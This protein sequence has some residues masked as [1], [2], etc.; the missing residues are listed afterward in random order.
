MCVCGQ[1]G[2]ESLSGMLL[3]SGRASEQ[4]QRLGVSSRDYYNKKKDPE[5]GDGMQC[6]Y[7]PGYIR[8]MPILSKEEINSVHWT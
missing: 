8:C 2:N 6:Q 7:E 5:R 1:K 4:I 3:T